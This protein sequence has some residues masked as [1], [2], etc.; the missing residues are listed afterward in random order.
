MTHRTVI[1]DFAY[2]GG[3]LHAEGV[4]LARIAAA[5]GTPFYCYSSAALERA[6]PR[7]SP[8]P[9]PTERPLI[10]YAVKANSNL[11]VIRTLAPARRR[12]RRGLRRR[13]APRA[14]RRHAR[15]SGSSFPASARRAARWRRARRR[16]P[17]DQCR[18]GARAAAAERRGDAR[19]AGPRRSRCASIPDVDAPHPC[20]D[21]DRQQ[22]NKF[23]ID[24]ARRRRRPTGSPATLPGIEPVGLAVHIGSQLTDL[25]PFA[26]AFD[27]LAELVRELRG[28]GLARRRASIS[29]AGSASATATRR[30]RADRRLCRAWSAR[31]RRR[32]TSR[33]PSSRA[34][35]S[36]A[37][38]ACWSPRVLYVKDGRD[39][40]LRHRRRGDER[41]DPPG[42]LRRLARHR[43]GS[44]RRSRRRARAGRR[45]RAGL[46]DRR[47]LRPRRARCRRLPRATSSRFTA[48]GAYGAVMSST[49]NSRLLVPEVLVAD[50]RFRRDPGAAE[51]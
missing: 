32:S 39:A 22:E 12:R 5:V 2:R 48:A 20:Q 17:P 28:D 1:T 49:Y 38:P 18:I 11:A 27:R 10:C 6:L 31:H 7:A 25:A 33:W 15:R 24:L 19:W 30:R 14:R 45:G 40:A 47:H 16:H 13:A 51:L 26:R 9:S 21:R 8:T 3:E 42:A 36:S 37:M 46:R 35:C 50:E 43:A 23:G 41:S 4:P 44:R 34:G 29:A